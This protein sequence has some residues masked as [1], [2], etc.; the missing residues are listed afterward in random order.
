MRFLGGLAV[1]LV[2]AVALAEKPKATA[3]ARQIDAMIAEEIGLNPGELAPPVGDAVFLR[4]AHLDLLGTIPAPEEVQR[5]VASQESQKRQELVNQLTKRPEYG[6]NQA[7]YWRDV[8]LSRRL[9]DRSIVVAPAMVEDLA[10]WIN[11]GEPWDAIARRFITATGTASD[12]GA[13]AILVAQDGR[14]EEIAAEVSRIFLG[15]QIQCAQC[16]D[17]PWDDWK[18][19]QFHELAAFFPRVG[20]RLVRDVKPFTLKVNVADRPDLP[21]LRTGANL[22]KRGRPEHYMQD[23]E[24]PEEVGERIE[25]RFFLTSLELPA[26]ARDAERRRALADD[27]TATDWFAMALVNRYW[28]ELVGE[29]FYEPV[30]DLGPERE[31]SAPKAAERLAEA[32]ATSGYDLRWLH[33]TILATDAYQRESRPRRTPDEKPFTANVAQP[34]R[35]DQLFDALLAAIDID[36]TQLRRIGGGGRGYGAVTPR[37]AF[38]AAFGYDPSDARSTVQATIP[39][40]LARMNTPQLNRAVQAIVA[41]LNRERDRDATAV[42]RDLYLRT[43][44]REPTD[45]EVAIVAEVASNAMWYGS[46]MEDLLWA[47]L[48]SAEFSHR[49]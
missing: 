46:A 34:L 2:G 32:F 11:D 33:R 12:N 7:R 41:R 36:E 16:H 39:Q 6:L 22:N 26:G 14:T 5:F 4:R 37:L 13:T 45:E 48:N 31:A 9:E 8:V 35:G 40:A 19:E 10:R 23:L 28:S 42:A 3:V 15:V 30:D 1:C 27:L 24:H 47:L 18:R 21:R 17:H 29:G 20:V 38:D 25:P 43:L 49:R 44:S